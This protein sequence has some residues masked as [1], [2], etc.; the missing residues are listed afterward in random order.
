M[1]L[2][3]RFDEKR[4]GGGERGGKGAA[5]IS[6]WSGNVVGLT[7]GG[8]ISLELGFYSLQTD[9]CLGRHSRNDSFWE[10]DLDV[11]KTFVAV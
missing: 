3:P 8:K 2:W 5:G 11:H 1:L 10:Q 4:C 9:V 6:T 7:A